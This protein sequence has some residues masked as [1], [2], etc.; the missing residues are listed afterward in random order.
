MATK[1]TRGGVVR[2]SFGRGGGADYEGAVV[3][4][5]GRVPVLD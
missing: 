2:G 4:A 5:E 3:R 1:V